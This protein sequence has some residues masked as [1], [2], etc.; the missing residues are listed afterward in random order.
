MS[1]RFCL[2]SVAA[3][4]FA[5]VSTSSASNFTFFSVGNSLT[6]DSNIQAI[7]DLAAADGINVT[8]AQHIHSGVGLDYMWNNPTDLT[9]GTS[10]TTG[11]ANPLNAVT[12][13]PFLGKLTDVNTGTPP[14][15]S[16]DVNRTVDFMNFAK[17]A[18]AANV[19]TQFYIFARWSEQSTWNPSFGAAA[20]GGYHNQWS[21]LYDPTNLATTE[22]G[23]YFNQLITQVRAAQPQDMKPI[24]LIPTGFVFDAIDQALSK[25]QLSGLAA[26]GGMPA[27]YRDELHLSE[28]GQF[29]ATTTFYSTIFHE[30][31]VGVTPPSEYPGLDAT[32]VSDLESIIWNVVSTNPDTGV[33]EP[34][35]LS[36]LA[37]G[38]ACVLY[39]PR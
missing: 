21:T 39:R 15:D 17:N 12:L 38:A 29:I 19:N 22:A 26:A 32:T 2:L 9:T 37:I 11:L 33:P 31:P 30:D 6:V 8:A 13:E 36:L 35:S 3:L 16:G 7:T 1:R 5:F 25:G 23:D 14:T 20:P 4:L 10:Y 24:E 34:A 28:L 18:N 27:L